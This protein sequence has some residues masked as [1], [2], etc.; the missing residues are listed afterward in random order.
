MVNHGLK[1]H[2]GCGNE[3]VATRG[4]STNQIKFAKMPASLGVFFVFA[5]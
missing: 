5:E 3:R 4:L 1:I 2:K